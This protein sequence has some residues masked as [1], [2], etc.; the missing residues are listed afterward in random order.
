MDFIESFE[1]EESEMIVTINEEVD[2]ELIGGAYYKCKV[3]ADTF[4]AKSKEYIRSSDLYWL[5]AKKLFG[6][7]YG[8]KL[9]KHKSYVV[10]VKHSKNNSD[11]YV[12]KLLGEITPALVVKK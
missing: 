2:G 8:F 4:D 5:V 9:L 12:T 3:S 1:K 10:K 7:K 6:Y 11:L